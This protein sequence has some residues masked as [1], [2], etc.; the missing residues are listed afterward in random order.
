MIRVGNG[1]NETILTLEDGEIKAQTIPTSN[2]APKKA[3]HCIQPLRELVFTVNDLYQRLSQT[4]HRICCF[5]LL[6]A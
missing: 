1:N 3:E 5:F 2:E 6:K 4:N